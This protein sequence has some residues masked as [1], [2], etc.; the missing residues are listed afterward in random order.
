MKLI[1]F[2]GAPASGKSTLAEEISRRT[3]IP[4][5]SKDGCKIQLF[6][7]YGFTSHEEKKRLSLAGENR[8]Y[9]LLEQAV[10]ENRDIIADNNFK[11]FDRIRKMLAEMP[12]KAEV[13]CIYCHAEYDVLARRYNERNAGGNR[14]PALYTLNQYPVIPGVSEFHKKIDAGDVERI[15]RNNKEETIGRRVL[16]VDTNHIETEFEQLC[17]RIEQHIEA[18]TV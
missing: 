17:Q 11:E 10:S 3:G 6:E 7:Q 9:E 14:H 15:Q 13:I 4:V 16:R 2:T 5:I 8:M 12:G 18:G 1:L